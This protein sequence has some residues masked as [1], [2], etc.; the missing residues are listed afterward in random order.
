MGTAVKKLSAVDAAFLYAETPEMPMHVGSLAYFTLPDGYAGDFFE[1]FKNVIASRMAS[2]P[3]LKWKLEPAPFDID[4]PSWIVDEQFDIDRHIYRTSLPAPA[5]AQVAERLTGWMHAKLLNRA[6]PLWEFYIFDGL[7]NN[8]VIVYNKI[9]HACI[10]GG[11][12]AALAQ[13]IYDLNPDGHGG[14]TPLAAPIVAN[15]DRGGEFANVG[16]KLVQSYVDFLQQPFKWMTSLPDVLKEIPPMLRTFVDPR[17]LSDLVSRTSPKTPINR[18]ISS[19][20]SFAG[21][22]LSFKRAKAIAKAADVKLNDVVLAIASGALRRY[23][24]AENAL[25]STSMTA[26]VPISLRK[27]GDTTQENQVMA[28]IC[29]LASDIEDPKARLLAISADAERSKELINPFRTMMPLYS[30]SSIPG[31][32]I[33]AQVLA[34]LYSRS[35]IADVM[36]PPANVVVS[37]VAGPRMTLYAAGAELQHLYP[38]SIAAHGI[39]LNITVSSYRDDL[40]FGLIA[41]ANL[42]PDVTVITKLLPAVLEELEIAVGIVAAESTPSLK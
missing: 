14:A 18:A 37:N 21:I 3:M 7:P 9:H 33:Y 32:P 11:A 36:P 4:H 38:V 8:E 13:I 31:A 15:A 16:A 30:D 1:A 22:S 40:D 35:N 12:G 20:R 10:D 42:I 41:A 25:P 39:G 26:F 6:R 19:E 2:A 17:I 27:P 28:M 29:S 34:I 23:L 24:L 5:T